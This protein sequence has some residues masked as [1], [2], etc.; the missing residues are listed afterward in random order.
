MKIMTRVLGV[1]AVMV[2]AGLVCAASESSLLVKTIG[3]DRKVTYEVMTGAEYKE[4]IKRLKLEERYFSKAVTQASKEWRMDK[5]NKGVSFPA[6]HLSAR[7]VSGNPQRFSSQEKAKEQADK[8]DEAAM[9]REDRESERNSRSR[10]AQAQRVKEESA[11]RASKLVESIIEEMMSK[12][13]D[14]DADKSDKGDK[15]V[16]AGVA[17][18]GTKMGVGDAKVGA[19]PARN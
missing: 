10:R 2:M 13:S 9:K 8:Y 6:A 3:F 15:A 12:T 19:A 4:F 1:F 17:V 14:G 18:G 11:G 5:Q 16:K 7:M